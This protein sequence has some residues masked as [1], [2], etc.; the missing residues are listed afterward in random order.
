M[1]NPLCILALLLVSISI[2][3]YLNKRYSIETSTLVINTL[4]DKLPIS[5]INKLVHAPSSIVD[6][7]AVGMTIA[8]NYDSYKNFVVVYDTDTIFYLYEAFKK[9]FKHLNKTIVLSDLSSLE[10]STSYR[11]IPNSITVIIE[12]A[13]VKTFVYKPTKITDY[14]PLN[15]EVKT[16]IVKVFPGITGESLPISA[17]VILLDGYKSGELPQSSDFLTKLADLKNKGV[18]IVSI[19]SE[20]VE[21]PVCKGSTESCLVGTL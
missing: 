21:F 4:P 14:A 19:N 5:C 20:C 13:I 11:A 2:T 9:S 8:I 3:F 17:N 6:W 18:K 16:A 7:N 1:T 12:N 15:T 10:Y